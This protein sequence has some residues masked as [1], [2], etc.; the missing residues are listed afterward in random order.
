LQYNLDAIMAELSHQQVSIWH[1]F[2]LALQ[3]NMR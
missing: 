1:L 3:V 2:L